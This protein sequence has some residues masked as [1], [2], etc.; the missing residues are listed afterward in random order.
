MRL[1]YPVP[2]TVLA[3]TGAETGFFKCHDIRQAGTG[4][5]AHP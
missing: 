2:G 3:G 5:P 4:Y 1:R